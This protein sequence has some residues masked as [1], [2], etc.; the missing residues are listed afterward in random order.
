MVAL[1]PLCIRCFVVGF[2]MVTGLAAALGLAL[3]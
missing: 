2:A 3:P 1:G